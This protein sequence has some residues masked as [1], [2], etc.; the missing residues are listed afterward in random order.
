MVF[1]PTDQTDFIYD[2]IRTIMNSINED[3][4]LNMLN[5]TA[6]L[7]QILDQNF[8]KQHKLTKIEKTINNI[9]QDD[10]RIRIL[11]LLQRIKN[12]TDTAIEYYDKDIGQDE[13]LYYQEEFE[14]DMIEIQAQIRKTLAT[15]IKEKLSGQLEL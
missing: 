15:I 13:R 12:E 10:T 7:L 9:L 14:K 2:Q 6:L 11:K 1:E 5:E 4:Y 3:K 8:K